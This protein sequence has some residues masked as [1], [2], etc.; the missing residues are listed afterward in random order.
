[1]RLP[2]RVFKVQGDGNLHFVEEAQTLDAAKASVQS[3]AKLWPGEYIIQN[4]ETGE[5]VVI[6][7]GRQTKN[8]VDV[9]AGGWPR[10]N[11]EKRHWVAHPC[12]SCKGGVFFPGVLVTA[13]S[14][15]FIRTIRTFLLLRFS[16][17][18]LSFLPLAVAAP[19]NSK[20]EFVRTYDPFFSADLRR[21]F[22]LISNFQPLTFCF[23]S[24]EPLTM[25]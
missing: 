20:G 8:W 23:P 4:E 24:S 16:P 19:L 2:F 18:T 5:R 10:L 7:S 21:N 17:L 12:V 11:S 1:M 3:L 13:A 14:S 25:Y 22:F 6:T 9:N 15:G